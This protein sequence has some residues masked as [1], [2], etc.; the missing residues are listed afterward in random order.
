MESIHE[1]L[2]S[3][4]VGAVLKTLDQFII[5]FA[6]LIPNIIIAIIFLLFTYIFSV[7][8]HH[9]IYSA[10]S[11]TS[12]RTNLVI[13]FQKLATTIIWFIGI[14]ISAAIVFPSVTTANLL[15][16]LGLT[17]VAVG[18][19]FKTIFE[20]FF[21]GI[22]LLLREPFHIGDYIV[23]QNQDGYVDHISINNTHL[24]RTDGVRVLVPNTS[25]YTNSVQILTDAE[26]RREKAACSIDFSAD[27][28]KARSA[29]TNAIKKSETVDKEKYIQVYAV[30]FSSNGVDFELYWWTKS[31]PSEIRR[32]RDEVL[33]NIKKALDAEKISMTYSTPVSFLDPLNIQKKSH[34]KDTEKNQ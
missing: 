27:I 19:A 26:T 6:T 12:M 18:F 8:I 9:L 29:I 25:M 5:N 22:I 30:S 16:T 20:N 15:A 3:K 17:S 14:L 32:S 4:Y 33:T 11:R 31:K 1:L 13:I 21:A 23:V 7:I 24:R 34:D 10:L 28:E 2:K